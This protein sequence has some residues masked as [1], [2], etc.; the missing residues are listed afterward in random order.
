[1]RIGGATHLDA[2]NVAV[3]DYEEAVVSF[4]RRIAGES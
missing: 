3:A 2:W 1:L 4:V